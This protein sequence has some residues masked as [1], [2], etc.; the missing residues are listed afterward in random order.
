MSPQR[1]NIFVLGLD[2]ANLPTLNALPDAAGYRLHPLLTIE[3]LQ[4]ARCRS[5]A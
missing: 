4:G 1:K 5:P 2:E 3:E